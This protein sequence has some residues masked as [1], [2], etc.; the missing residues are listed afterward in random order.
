MKIQKVFYFS[1]FIGTIA[2]FFIIKFNLTYLQLHDPN[3]F[4]FTIINQ[5]TKFLRF[6]Y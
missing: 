5:Y 6:F 3:R 2:I 1:V 4:E